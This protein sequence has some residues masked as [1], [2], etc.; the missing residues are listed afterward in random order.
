MILK[1]LE[2]VEKILKKEKP[3]SPPAGQGGPAMQMV[4]PNFPTYIFNRR[5]R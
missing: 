1:F 3:A 5:R 2:L 4:R